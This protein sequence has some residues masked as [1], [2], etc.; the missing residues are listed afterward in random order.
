MSKF[1]DKL[2]QLSRTAPQSIGFKAAQPS[3]AKPRMQIIVSLAEENVEQLVNHAT[4]VDAGLLRISR[5]ASGAA[6]LRKLKETLPDIL[7]GIRQQPGGKKTSKQLTAGC[8]FIVFPAAVTPLVA[9]PDNDKTGKI[10]EVE[11]SI[12]EGLLRA[13][14]ELPLD[15]VLISSE[16]E[17]DQS[18]TW[19][20]LMLFRRFADLLTK[21]LLVSVPSKVT[22]LE[23]QA[24]WEAGVK[25][26]IT[27]ITPEQPEDRLKDLRRIIDGLPL[28]TREHEKREPLLPRISTESDAIAVEEEEDE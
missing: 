1:I 5:Q 24:L 17:K 10:L 3:L 4:G 11:A 2:K 22:A 8:D 21:P 13:A 23:L 19:H 18:L 7:W 6:A 9:L 28:P 20:Q 27:A 15:A 12:S 16:T 14:N 26:I 25:G